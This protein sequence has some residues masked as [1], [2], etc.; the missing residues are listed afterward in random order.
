MINAPFLTEPIIANHEPI[1]MASIEIMINDV[2]IYDRN[3]GMV[4]DSWFS[5]PCASAARAFAP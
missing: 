5:P 3:I 4:L 1:D 2:K